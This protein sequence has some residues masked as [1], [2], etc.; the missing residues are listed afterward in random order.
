M[1][2][3]YINPP[4][5]EELKVLVED[6]TTA[7]RMHTGE[8]KAIVLTLL[9][10]R[11]DETIKE[12]RAKG[13]DQG[14]PDEADMKKMAEAVGEDAA[15]AVNGIV[16]GRGYWEGAAIMYAVFNK[17]KEDILIA[18]EVAQPQDNIPIVKCADCHDVHAKS[19][20]T[21]KRVDK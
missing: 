8:G 9:R 19:D 7:L 16:Y 2:K 5:P 6:A 1:K 17:F 3:A 20:E 4:V 14:E 10:E 12:I 11:F 15:R 18:N 13:F 21:A